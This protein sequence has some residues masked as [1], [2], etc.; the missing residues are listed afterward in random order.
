MSSQDVWVY[1]P[2]DADFKVLEAAAESGSLVK[3]KYDIARLVFCVPN[4]I[5]SHAELIK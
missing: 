3:V 1:V 4:D 2:N 5:M